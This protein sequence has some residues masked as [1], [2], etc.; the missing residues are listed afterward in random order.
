ML[1]LK[2]SNLASFI[3]RERLLL[4]SLWDTLY[5]SHPQRL[6]QFPAYSI[7]VE[8][9]RVWNEKLGCEEEEVSEN[10]SEELLVAHERER[11]RVEQEVEEARPLLARLGRYFEVVDKWRELEVC[12][13]SP[14]R[15]P[16]A[17]LRPPRRLLLPIHLACLT[18]LVE[19]LVVSRRKRRTGNELS[20]KGQRYAA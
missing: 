7:S 15:L 4:S 2:R 19:L 10:V 11:E 8:P 17:D 13:S 14:S 18:S 20:E 16:S 12:L 6:A 3:Q 5:L 9:T 1:L